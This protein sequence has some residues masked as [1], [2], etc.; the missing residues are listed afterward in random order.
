MSREKLIELI[1]AVAEL[2]RDCIAKEERVKAFREGFQKGVGTDLSMYLQDESE[3]VEEMA[4]VGGGNDPETEEE[5][6]K[7]A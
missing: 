2:R 4:N 6:G 7:N 3:P 1:T 5:G